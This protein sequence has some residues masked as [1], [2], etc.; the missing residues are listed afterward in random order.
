MIGRIRTPH[1][2]LYYS[3]LALLALV[4]LFEEWGWEPLQR[5]LARV[6]RW[7]GLR[8]IEGCVRALPPWAA[9]AV[10]L[11]PTA[12]LLPVK[13]LALWAVGRGHV[14]LGMLV[15]VLAKVV[16]TAV[17][18]RLFSLTQPALMQLH[19]FAWT[20]AHWMRL[21]HAV[22]E[23]ARAALEALGQVYDPRFAAVA[24]LAVERAIMVQER[25]TPALMRQ[26]GVLGTAV[27][28]TPGGR[29]AIRVYVDRPNGPELPAVLDGVPVV[30]EVTGLFV[31]L[32][33]PTRRHRPAPLGFSVGHPRITAGTIGARVIDGSGN[34]YILS[35]NHVLANIN[36]AQIGDPILQP[37]PYD[38]GTL[39]NDAIATLSAFQPIDFTANGQNTMD[40]AIALTNASDVLNSTPADDG[41]GTP[42]AS[43]HGDA[44]GDGFFD[45]KSALLNVAVTKYGR[46]T[47]LT[48]GQITGINATLSIC[49][50][51]V[52]VFCVRSATFQ[53]QLV[54][55]PGGF[56]AGGDSGSLIV[57]AAG[58]NPVGLLFAGSTAQ[59]VANRIDLVLDRFGV[60]IDAG[61][62]PPPAPVTDIA[63][64]AVSAP[65]SATAGAT[66][67]VQVAVRNIG[68]TAVTE[69]IDV[70]LEDVTDGA[71]IG[72]RTVGGLA[73]GA[74][75]N[76]TFA[77]NTTGVSEGAHTLRAAHALADDNAA[78]DAKTTTVTIN[79]PGS[80]GGIHVGDLDGIP[81]NDGRTWSA[82]VEVTVHDA[83]HQ[84]ID[85]ATV[86]GA[87]NTSG[88]ASTVCTTGELGGNGTCIFLF[89]GLRKK[90]VSFTITTV[91]LPGQTYAAASNHDPDGDSN[92]TTI[93]VIRP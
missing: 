78:N 69:D 70:A 62:S 85:G 90:S 33:E 81:S 40:A 22:L 82:I 30:R 88:L 91:V 66:V 34:V 24:Q 49:Y 76:L 59:T 44:N 73:A 3:L 72:S 8:W 12:L 7:P 13:L 15:I 86:T 61:T 84:P 37:G 71:T 42:S 45:N 35:N 74:T 2:I 87:W 92:G 57:A 80:A 28:L 68:N 46:T 1:K 93:T 29:A 67:D 64:Q 14:V 23:R 58:L 19:W 39:P 83:N 25:F 32:S 31:A 65:A 53:D 48:Q 36:D 26:P 4:I 47:E 5:L 16:G 56:S 6:G 27:G 63:I 52:I 18:A 38:G 89:P 50:E 20:Y 51:V 60:A 79:L 43:I 75:A 10:F 54:I 55:T 17:V 11:L 21:K 41:Y 9:V 77:W